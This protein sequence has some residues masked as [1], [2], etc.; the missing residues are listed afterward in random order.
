M[1]ELEEDVGVP[2]RIDRLGLR[3]LVAVRKVR[4]AVPVGSGHDVGVAVTVEV[5]SRRP[6]GKE[7]AVELLRLEMDEVQRLRRLVSGS[8]FPGVAG[9][10]EPRAHEAPQGLRQGR[11]PRSSGHRFTPT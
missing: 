9:E 10:Q 5:T 6:F 2:V 4:P 1:D 11:R 8:R 3:E 7:A